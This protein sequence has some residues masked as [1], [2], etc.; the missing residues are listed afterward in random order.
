MTSIHCDSELVFNELKNK[1]NIK[2]E[3]L[4]EEFDEITE[5]SNS[6]NKFLLKEK[7]DIE[8]MN[9]MAQKYETVDSDIIKLNVGGTYFSTLKSTL[10]KKIKKQNENGFYDPHLLQSLISGMIKINYD[11]NKAIFIDR[12]PK[13]FCH[14]LDYLR[15]LD[16]NKQFKMPR[17]SKEET[18]EFLEEAEYFELHGILDIKNPL[19][20]LD[21]VVFLNDEEKRKLLELCNFSYKTKWKRLYRATIDGFFA[22]NFHTKCDGNANTLT[23]IKTTNN[24]IF[25][26]YTTVAWDQKL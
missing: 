1:H 21:S 2:I 24:Y 7:D 10:E 15:N 23:I 8:K 19:I 4:K 18:I 14:I 9:K 13:Y 12:N 25:G 3:K 5:L 16:S 26:G 11:E 22:K 17:L 6:M 20:N